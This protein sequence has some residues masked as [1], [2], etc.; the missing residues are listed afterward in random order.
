MKGALPSLELEQD[1]TEKQRAEE[2][3][4]HGLAQ[5]ENAFMRTVGSRGD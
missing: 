2:Q 1:I 5:L 4:Q 3:I